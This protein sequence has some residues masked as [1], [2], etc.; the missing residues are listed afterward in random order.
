[1]IT[2]ALYSHASSMRAKPFRLAA[3]TAFIFLSACTVGPNYS[4]PPVET[5]GQYKEADVSTMSKSVADVVNANWWEIFGDAVLNGLEQ[6][7]DI[8][9]QN[10]AQA[11][12][13]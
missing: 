10:V 12:A 13:A 7:V 8:S 9:N 4:R 3:F 1:M 2:S 11:E 6:Q 5:P